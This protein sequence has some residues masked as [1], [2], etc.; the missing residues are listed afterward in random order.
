[1]HLDG[2]S[3]HDNIRL[4][5]G[6]TYR[7]RIAVKDPDGDSIRYLWQL[8]N[9][10]SASQVGGEFEEDISNLPGLILDPDSKDTQLIAPHD[11]GAYRLFIYAYDNHGHAAH[12]NIPFYVGQ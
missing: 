7:A 4:K 5:A 10:S 11:P 2:K 12:A 9:E 6:K 1:M 3:G 8:K